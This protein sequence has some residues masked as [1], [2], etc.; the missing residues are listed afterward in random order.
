LIAQRAALGFRVVDSF[1][2][3]VRLGDGLTAN[4][5]L[6]A[7]AMARTTKAVAVCA[8]KIYVHRP[9][10]TRFVATQAC[11]SAR[12]GASFLHQLAQD[13]GMCFEI[14]QPDEEARLAVLGCS[15]LF[16][17]TADGALVV[18]IGGGSTELS[19]AVAQ[20]GGQRPRLHSFF[21]AP[22]GVV[23]LAEMFPE[24]D[25][26]YD[27]FDDMR[28]AAGD[29]LQGFEPDLDVARRL[30]SGAA[31]IIGTS[32]A[33]TSLAGVHLKLE[34]YTRKLVDGLWI[35]KDDTF[36]AIHHLATQ[37]K[38]G[39][40]AHPCIGNERADLVV[41]GAAILAAVLD[42]WPSPRLRVADRGLR[43][44]LILSMLQQAAMSPEQS[45]P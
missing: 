16:D 5:E 40:A 21:S 36:S 11:R 26:R 25:N 43:E 13:T 34:R 32:G 2:R 10:H 30:Q 9:A 6:S 19:W 18:D 4:G 17:P 24:H 41:A 39:R 44:G 3:V 27:W 42:R 23:S 7:E 28:R 14:I 45:M 37:D 29:L 22:I 20:G 35:S 38:A 8:E 33:I 12:N 1:S 15:D 31:H